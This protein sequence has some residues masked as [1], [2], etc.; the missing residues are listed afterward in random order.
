VSFGSAASFVL[1]LLRHPLLVLPLAI[2]GAVLLG[3]FRGMGLPR[4][5][6][7][8][9]PLHRFVAGAAATLLACEVFFVAFLLDGDGAPGGG[10]PLAGYAAWSAVAWALFLAACALV[11]SFAGGAWGT[12][13]GRATRPFRLTPEIDFRGDGSAVPVTVAVPVLGFLAGA[14][15]GGVLAWLVVFGPRAFSDVA[16]VDALATAVSGWRA[17][18][19]PLLHLS[20]GLAAVLMAVSF[21]LLRNRATPAVGISFLL[22]LAVAAEGALEFWLR[23]AGIAW[24]AVL[25]ALVV[26]GTRHYKVR[27]SEL[28]AFYASPRPYPPVE[29]GGAPRVQPLPLDATC[30]AWA[31]SEARPLILVCASGGGLRAAT[32]TAGVLG[33]LDALS[34]F[35]QATRLVTGASGGMVGAAAWIALA[36]G[37]RRGDD[38]KPDA[39]GLMRAV[40]TMDSLTPVARRLV[41]HDIPLAFLPIVNHSDRGEALAR[42]FEAHLSREL[43]C[44]MDLSLGDLREAESRGELPSLVFS[45]MLVED[46]RRLLLGNLDLAPA[47]DHLVRWLSSKEHGAQPSTGLASRT[48]YHLSQV[49]PEV[50]E[51]FRL[52]T[53]A[54]LSAAFPY[55][56][57]ATLLP[58]RARRRVVDAGYFDNYGPELACSWLRRL[59]VVR[60]DWFR[61]HVSRVLVIQIR[62]NVSR[63]SVNPETRE[64]GRDRRRREARQG[65]AAR[66]LEGVSSPPEGLLTARESVMLFRNDARLEALGD[67]FASA[68]YPEDFLTTTVFE[69]RGEA[70]LSWTLSPE[71]MAGMV[72]QVESEGIGQKLDAVGAWLEAPPTVGGRA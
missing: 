35:R 21:V 16:W 25:L 47:T 5:F 38:P 51:K 58:T 56:S 67:L 29:G 36:L 68:G 34:G 15:V 41:F 39:L 31:S 22:G 61:R 18:N 44:R 70:S 6:W 30:D 69:F 23:S 71:E 20:A 11:R 33:R 45:P 2:V 24:T 10:P 65:C 40:G 1:A 28:G 26:A 46:G 59:L 9:R 8:E 53:A 63:L 3:A 12:A 13:R 49:I 43:R 7:H 14:A 57:P 64:A 32:W 72:S 17:V 48:A 19:D 54:R 27:I 52:F 4:L 66:G 55:V 37:R 62:D 60:S 50:W 42:S